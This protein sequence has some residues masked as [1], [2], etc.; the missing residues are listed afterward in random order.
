MVII[1]LL[2]VITGHYITIR[3]QILLEYEYGSYRAGHGPIR[4]METGGILM[5]R[6]YAG[7]ISAARAPP[8]SRPMYSLRFPL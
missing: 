6:N 1:F 3:V 7:Y 5:E 4:S 2:Q 8:A